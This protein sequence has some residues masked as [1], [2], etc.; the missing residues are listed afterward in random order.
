[1]T[2]QDSQGVAVAFLAFED[3]KYYCRLVKMRVLP[4]VLAPAYV[5]TG[6]LPTFSIPGWP[7]PSPTT[8][9]ASAPAA[10][11]GAPISKPS[12]ISISSVTYSGKG[13]PSGSVSTSL[14]ADKTVSDQLCAQLFSEGELTRYRSLLSVLTSS[15]RT[16]ARVRRWRTAPRVATSS[17]RSSTH[18]HTLLLWCPARTMATRSSTKASRESSPRPMFSRRSYP[19]RSVRVPASWAGARWSQG[20][21]TQRAIR[22]QP[23]TWSSAHAVSWELDQRLCSTSETPFH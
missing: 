19:P 15:K 12:G 4:L 17:S 2:S 9:K 18:Q 11:T 8:V 13:C 6:I 10:V 22:S 1:M 3:P 5:L 14:S 23:L 7:S 16:L 21:S 20:L